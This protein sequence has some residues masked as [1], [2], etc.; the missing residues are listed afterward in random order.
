MGSIAYRVSPFAR[1]FF[2]IIVLGF[3]N[4]LFGYLE[5]IGNSPLSTVWLNFFENMYPALDGFLIFL[6]LST[7]INSKREKKIGQ[8]AAFSLIPIWLFFILLS[9]DSIFSHYIS[10]P[11]FDAGYEILLAF[12]SAYVCLRLTEYNGTMHR[13]ELLWIVIGIFFMNFCTFFIYSFVRSEIGEQVWFISNIVNLITYV[14]YTYGFYY[15][16]IKSKALNLQMG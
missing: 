14:I 13:K 3:V 16:Y 6:F 8:F 4:D 9:D 15:A 10:H 11:I 12:A 1:P 7:I 2:F 5:H